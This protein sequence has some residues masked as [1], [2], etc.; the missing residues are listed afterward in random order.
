[1][2]RGRLIL[3]ME[4]HSSAVLLIFWCFPCTLPIFSLFLEVHLSAS[5]SPSRTAHY[6]KQLK[7]YWYVSMSWAYLVHCLFR[8]FIGWGSRSAHWGCWC[9]RH[10]IIRYQTTLLSCHFWGNL[11]TCPFPWW[12]FLYR[13][14]CSSYLLTLLA[15]APFANFLPSQPSHSSRNWLQVTV[16]RVLALFSPIFFDFQC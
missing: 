3:E 12:C 13:H 1:M 7:V 4:G 2:E 11:F 6:L 10:S 14:G 15:G 16:F 8:V 5:P 9:Y